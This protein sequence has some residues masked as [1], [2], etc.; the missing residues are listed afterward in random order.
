[1]A[2][3]DGD[4][5]QSIPPYPVRNDE[6]STGYDK[7]SCSEHSS[8]P[9]HLGVGLKKIDRFENSLGYKRSVLLGVF[10]DEGSETDKMLY[11]STRPHNL[12]RGAL[13]SPTLSQVLSHFET[14]S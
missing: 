2:V 11:R 8:W 6:G 1:M 7:F 14:F 13:V 4:E 3:K 5:F 9:A 12:H 10:G